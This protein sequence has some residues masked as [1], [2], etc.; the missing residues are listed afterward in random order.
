MKLFQNRA[1]TPL[2]HCEHPEKYEVP[3]IGG[4]DHLGT[5]DAG[6]M[7][8]LVHHTVVLARLDSNRVTVRAIVLTL[9]N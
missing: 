1:Q 7:E 2:E 5:F 6:R 8:P 9:P 4:A 3:V